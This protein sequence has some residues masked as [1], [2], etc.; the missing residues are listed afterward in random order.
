MATVLTDL[1]RSGTNPFA[2]RIAPQL[3]LDAHA[4][5]VPSIGHGAFDVLLRQL[6]E[7]HADPARPSSGIVLLGE[8]GSGKTHLLHR[9]RAASAAVANFCPIDT[10]TLAAGPE[11]LLLRSVI[12]SLARQVEVG[13]HDH[14]LQLIARAV[15]RWAAPQ[16]RRRESRRE[17]LAEVAQRACERDVRLDRTFTRVFLEAACGTRRATAMEWL[18]G[19]EL[20]ADERSALGNPHPLHG[21]ESAWVALQ[22]MAILA[23]LHRLLV[24]VLDVPRFEARAGEDQRLPHLLSAMASLRETSPNCVLLLSCTESTWKDLSRKLTDFEVARLATQTLR[25]QPLSAGESIELVAA[26]MRAFAPELDG[27]DAC[28]PFT[29]DWIARQASASVTPRELLA[30]CHE[31]LERL[32][33]DGRTSRSPAADKRSP[34][35]EHLDRIFDERPAGARKAVV[36][37]VPEAA[38]A[39]PRPAL[40]K[41]AGRSASK[42]HK[43]KDREKVSPEPPSARQVVRHAALPDLDDD[44]FPHLSPSP[45]RAGPEWKER[46]ERTLEKLIRFLDAHDCACLGED[47]YVAPSVIRFRFM[48]KGSTKTSQVEK[49]TPQMLVKFQL[50]TEPLVRSSGKFVCIDFPREE[51]QEVVLDDLLQSVEGRQGWLALP[52]GVDLFGNIQWI[53]LRSEKTWHAY[54][55]GGKGTGK[56]NLLAS[57]ALALARLQTKEQVEFLVLEARPGALA[58]LED[59]PG[60]RAFKRGAEVVAAWHDLL[61]ELPSRKHE[62]RH[63]VVV[64]DDLGDVFEARKRSRAVGHIAGRLGSQAKHGLVHLL[65]STSRP[66]DDLMSGEFRGATAHLALRLPDASSSRLVVDEAGAEHLLGKG[67]LLARLRRDQIRLQ[68]PI[69]APSAAVPL[70]DDA[71]GENADADEDVLLPARRV[72]AGRG[73]G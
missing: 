20:A 67:D 37:P 29:R 39:A 41:I 24:L 71:S 49:L 22:N 43:E 63:L 15:L 3:L 17:I 38:P 31:E 34:F 48:P 72:R 26:R 64:A 60:L 51:R 9:V 56:S 52:L 33:Q 65:C 25:L 46:T 18:K 4:P 23:S 53:S 36:E 69:V 73:A 21:A 5:H 62:G 50:K 45:Y 1:L 70:A 58:A 42:E 28:H 16:G 13:T 10:G 55:A 2:D 30:T 19:T 32:V 35:S 14:Q 44:L 7:R 57:M 8:P 66:A 27:E 6:A 12:V 40:R 47:V 59:L 68:G 61:A 11:L 54:V